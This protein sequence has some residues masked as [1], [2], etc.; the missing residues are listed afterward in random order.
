MT[1]APPPAIWR[2][3]LVVPLVALVLAGCRLDVGT[4]VV[5][6]ARGA[7][8]VAVSVRIDGATLR[9]LDRL[10]VDP[11]IDADLTL[12]PTSLWRS[13][14]LVDQDG[15]LTHVYRRDFADGAELTA[16]LRELSDGIAVQD[17]ALR[18][19]VVATTTRRGALTLVGHAGVR[20][21]STT[22]VLIDDVPVGPSGRDLAA[23]TADAVRARLDV[24]VAGAVVES[25]ADRVG[26]RSAGWD[27]PVGELRPITLVAA[28]AGWWSR[29]PWTFVGL[30]GAAIAAVTLIR[31]RRHRAGA[32]STAPATAEDGSEG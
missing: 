17:P 3:L 28:P 14:R 16:V 9:E 18:F 2:R 6:D 21:P 5:V 11:G 1:P 4:D 26:E 32:A 12:G 7:G 29:V 23:L 8:T 22:G 31:V 27:L 15:G 19:D 25:D 10:G 13:E 20:P 24:S 30:L